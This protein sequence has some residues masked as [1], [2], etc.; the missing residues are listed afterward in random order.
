VHFL[1]FLMAI[2]GLPLVTVTGSNSGKRGPAMR[3]LRPFAAKSKTGLISPQQSL[4]V[5][6]QI[7]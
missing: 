1:G 6:V 7:L 3:R 5:L 4:A 2:S